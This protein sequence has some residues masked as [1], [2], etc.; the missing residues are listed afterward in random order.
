MTYNPEIH[1][2]RSIRLRDFDYSS[3]GAYFI[4]I[5]TFGREC[6]F[7]E[8]VDGEMSMDDA[9]RIVESVWLG[10]SD[11]FPSVEPDAFVVMPN[12]VHAIIVVN[13]SVGAVGAIHELPLQDRN[14]R[15]NMV[16]PKAIGYFKMNAAKQINTLRETPGVPVWQRNY[17]ERIIRNEG[18]LNGIREYIANNPRTWYDDEENPKGIPRQPM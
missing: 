1:H 3:S 18:E 16:L 2:R 4:S 8:I 11:R 13:A 10:L 15:R 6:L 5:C 17:H 12:H 14:A 7:G 9:G